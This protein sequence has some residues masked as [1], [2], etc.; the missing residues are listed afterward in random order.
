MIL[1]LANSNVRLFR[2]PDK[3]FDSDQADPESGDIFSINFNRE[4]DKAAGLGNYRLAIRLMFLQLL[5]NLSE[6][7]IIQYKH[8][9]TN[10]DYL[11]QLYSTRYY[12]DF[13]RITRH[14]EYSWY[15]QFE[16]NPQTYQ[17]IKKEFED[18]KPIIR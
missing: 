7:N 6:K 10:F 14:Y 9:R 12:E 16:V 17:V 2:R 18:F 13:F 11:S 3:T 5:K 1:Y 8:D 15:G 4:I